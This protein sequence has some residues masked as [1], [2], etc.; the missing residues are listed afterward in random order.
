M[1]Y[2]SKY[3]NARQSDTIMRGQAEPDETKF[4]LHKTIESVL[5]RGEYPDTLLD[6]LDP[7]S[8]Q[9]KIFYK[10]A[11][12]VPPFIIKTCF[13]SPNHGFRTRH[14]PGCES[15]DYLFGDAIFMHGAP[16]VVFSAQQNLGPAASLSTLSNVSVEGHRCKGDV[17]LPVRIF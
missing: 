8:A 17:K 5:Q 10:T 14:S 7:L 15:Q 11:H 4:I 13:G 6:R 12:K 3:Q 9:S 2:I 1:S 16:G